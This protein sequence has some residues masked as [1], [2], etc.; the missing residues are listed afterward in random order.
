MEAIQETTRF[1]ETDLV[2]RFARDE[3]FE[4][5]NERVVQMPLLG[6]EHSTIAGEIRQLLS[7]PVRD[8]K[9]GYIMGALI[10]I[11]ECDADGYISNMRVPDVSF[12]RRGRQPRKEDRARPF[13]GAPDLAVEIVSPGESVEELQGKIRVYLMYGSEQ[14][15]VL[16]PATR[17]LHQ[18]LQGEKHIRIYTEEDTLT[19]E[20]LFPG[21]ILRIADMFRDPEEEI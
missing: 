2:R 7:P 9:L 10:Y 6:Y 4:I 13:Y 16:Y 11:F 21:V 18:H 14:V 8:Q 12:I 5:S 15:W 19:A 3:R 20:S 17:E 1:T